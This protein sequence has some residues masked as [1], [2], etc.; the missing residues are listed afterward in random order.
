MDKGVLRRILFP[1]LSLSLSTSC[2]AGF[3][4]IAT[5]GQVARNAS[6]LA[7]YYYQQD[8]SDLWVNPAWQYENQRQAVLEHTE[9]AGA[10]TNVSEYIVGVYLGRNYEGDIVSGGMDQYVPSA[11]SGSLIDLSGPAITP[12]NIF[13]IVIAKELDK[14]VG[15]VRINYNSYSASNTAAPVGAVTKDEADFSAWDLNVIAGLIAKGEKLR[16]VSLQLGKPNIDSSATVITGGNTVKDKF[17]DGS[18]R[19]IALSGR[20]ELSKTNKKT[21]LVSFLIGS[22]DVSAKLVSTNSGAATTA[23]DTFTDTVTVFQGLFS[24]ILT[25]TPT[26]TVRISTGLNYT[27]ATERERTTATGAGATND[28]ETVSTATIIPVNA[29]YE[30]RKLGKSKKWTVRGAIS[31]SIY[32]RL[33]STTKDRVADTKAKADTSGSMPIS[34]AIGAAYEAWKGFVVDAQ[35]VQATLFEGTNLFSGTAGTFIN[36]VTVT[37]NYGS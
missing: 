31:K 26:T 27:K 4:G 15:G 3:D 16:E 36:R 23:T 12:N 21:N 5:S 18:A 20:A 9:F 32:S 19:T 6:M 7:N 30:M 33:S 22:D 34:F 1:A 28:D 35:I 14:F 17:T 37:W 11:S 8:K 13:D 10:S 25:V 29:A 24:S 2:F